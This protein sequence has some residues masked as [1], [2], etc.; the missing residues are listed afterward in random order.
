MPVDACLTAAQATPC[1]CLSGAYAGYGI[2]N[3]PDV[4]VCGAVTNFTADDILLTGGTVSEIIPVPDTVDYF[5]WVQV[6]PGVAALNIAM[7]PGRLFAC[8]NCGVYSRRAFDDCNTGAAV[9]RRRRPCCL[10]WK[11]TQL[12]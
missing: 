12:C 4:C 8:C 9:M 1:E 6:T 3:L 11:G 7:V 10:L 2:I 5:V